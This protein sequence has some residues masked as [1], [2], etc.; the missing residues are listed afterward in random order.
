MRK[1]TRELKSMGCGPVDER[2]SQSLTSETGC[3]K[4]RKQTPSQCTRRKAC[5]SGGKMKVMR[6]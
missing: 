2:R 4:E 5:V 6:W 1:P 3:R